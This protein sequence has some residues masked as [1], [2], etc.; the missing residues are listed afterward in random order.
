MRVPLEWLKEYVAVEAT[1][2]EVATR[3]TMGGLEV[4]GI[5]DSQLGKVLDV[6]ITPNRGDCLSMIGVAREVAA[7]YDLPLRLPSPPPSEQGGE[8]ANLVKVEILEPN[9]CPRYAGRVVSG[10]K[11]APSPEWMQVRLEAAGQR[12]I[13]NI[14]DVTNYVML[15]LGQPLHAFDLARLKGNQI[16]VRLANE[17]EVLK[18]LD[19]N[20][21]SLSPEMLVIADAEDA[22]AVAGVMGGADSEVNEETTTI[23]LESAHFNPLSVRRTSRLLGLRTEASYRFERVV[24]PSG[25]RRALD[26]ACE[27]LEQMG[28]P[29][30]VSGVV[31]VLVQPIENRTILFRPE[32]AEALLGMEVTAEIATQCLARLGLEVVAQGEHL[33]V[34]IPPSRSDLNIEEDLIEE[35]GRIHGYEKIPETLPVGDT[36]QG[37]DSASGRFAT[38]VRQSLTGCGLQEV[39]T[40]SLHSLPAFASGAEQANRV[41]IRNALSAE[42]GGLRYS[43]LPT[44]LDVAK[45]NAAFG[46]HDLALFEVGRIWHKQHTNGVLLPLEVL[47]VA[48]LVAGSF[49]IKGW[50]R[51][52]SIGSADF[53]LAKGI[54][55]RLLLDMRAHLDF[56]PLP[57]GADELPI[58]H[59]GRTARISA[60]SEGCAE[61]AGVI[62]YVGEL[63]PRLAS[64]IGVRERIYLFE[65]SFDALW[66]ASQSAD[67]P[68]HP[69]PRFP[70]VTRDLAPRLPEDVDYQRIKRLVDAEKIELLES[71]R[72][73]DV[74]RGNPLPEGVKSLTLSFTFRSS[75]RTLGEAE[76]STAME[77]IRQLLSVQCGASFVG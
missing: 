61:K 54:V 73:T 2:D 77:H 35:V 8:A 46:N 23:L 76:V 33:N 57:I 19:G 51:D 25:V 21:R 49:G 32:R 14:V 69:I 67:S 75:E 7:L 22:I 38:L 71:F 74:F 17:G 45:H 59:P 4:E 24:D 37:G 39:I 47:S 20:E 72:L 31:D 15:E 6:Y 66:V 56:E 55:E 50:Q 65:L 70:A 27:L 3:L 5:E 63:H 28:Q 42:V 60:N 26:R 53:W 68:F 41:E 1:A 16:R 11:V 48:G 9:H 58:F 13:N 10:I 64:G 43:L 52:A 34:T 62:G 18:T 40:H 30:A 29:A 44:M 12:P 36:T